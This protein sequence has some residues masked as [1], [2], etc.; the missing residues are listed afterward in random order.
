MIRLGLIIQF[1]SFIP[2]KRN[3]NE[4]NIQIIKIF[5][6]TFN[7]RWQMSASTLS[8]NNTT[9]TH[10]VL[11][12]LLF[13]PKSKT[14]ANRHW[15]V[16]NVYTFFS[17]L[18]NDPYCCDSILLIRFTS[19]SSART[20]TH[21]V[22]S[23]KANKYFL[24][25]SPI[26]NRRTRCVYGGEPKYW[27]LNKIHPYRIRGGNRE[28]SSTYIHHYVTQTHLGERARDFNKFY[29]EDA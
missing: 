22:R 17:L 7:M 24:N 28:F 23:I 6:Y 4:S 18:E 9:L 26:K 19:R 5:W 12:D 25:L 3:H 2:V 11:C 1:N 16:C 8:P 27:K 10:T 20:H 15:A 13:R 14:E 21:F 29:N